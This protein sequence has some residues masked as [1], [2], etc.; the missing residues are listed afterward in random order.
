[1]HFD[2]LLISYALGISS[3]SKS[4]LN[5]YARSQL[6]SFYVVKWIGDRGLGRKG[7][8]L[9]DMINQTKKSAYV[10]VAA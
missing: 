6:N 5:R 3:K 8:S 9:I 4:R 1:M 10:K 2:A 7:T